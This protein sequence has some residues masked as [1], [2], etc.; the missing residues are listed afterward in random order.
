LHLGGDARRALDEITGEDLTRLA[1]GHADPAA[2]GTPHPPVG[3]GIVVLQRVHRFA[4]T[5]G[6]A[7]LAAAIQAGD[8]D[9]VV[10]VLADDAVADV[11]WVRRSYDASDDTTTDLAAVRADVTTVGARILAAAQVGDATAALEAVEEARVLC[12]HRRGPFGV[13]TWVPRVEDWLGTPARTHG[14]GVAWQVG[15]PVLA[16]Q[17]DHQLRIYN[18]DVGVVVATDD[19]PRVAFPRAEGPRLI[20]PGRL[21]A[22]EPVHAM[23]IH[24]SQGSQFRHAVVVLPTED[25]RILSRELL[26]TG[27]TRAQQQVTVVGSEAAVRAAVGRVVQRASGLRDRLWGTA[28]GAGH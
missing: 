1:A 21:E 11:R 13:A 10:Q 8:D 19:G 3:D 4:E 2:T 17:N 18:G 15:T 16:T 5:S 25:S 12:A 20:P 28:P 7:D 26:Y 22:L 9:A 14:P 27:V 6:I 24:K 23:T